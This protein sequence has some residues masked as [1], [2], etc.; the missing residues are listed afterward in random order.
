MHTYKEV[1][2]YIAQTIAQA[3]YMSVDEIE[4][5]Q[6]FSSFGLESITLVKVVEK[7]ND[8]YSCAIEVRELLPYQ[9]LRDAST[10]VFKKISSSEQ[11][12][13]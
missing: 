4:E 11:L 2:D 12:A 13:S 1:Q 6:L 8:K 7:M 5:D 9:T 10:Y 3:M